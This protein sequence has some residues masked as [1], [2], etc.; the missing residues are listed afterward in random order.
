MDGEKK[1]SFLKLGIIE[2]GV[3]AIVIFVVVGILIY[4]NAIP[5]P[6]FISNLV[7]GKGGSVPEVTVR[8]DIPVKL[9]CPVA[10]SDCRNPRETTFQNQPAITYVLESGD[11]IFSI[12]NLLSYQ[13][14]NITVGNVSSKK[15]YASYIQDNTCYAV[16][17]IIPDSATVKEIGELPLPKGSILGTIGEDTLS[18]NG[19][20][21]SLLVQI[22][23]KALDPKLSNQEDFLKCTVVNTKPEDM[24]PYTR[25]DPT[26]FD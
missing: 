4:F 17:Y 21:F 24:G 19:T 18:L 15:L 26:N 5:V 3:V 20:S 7:S 14:S 2:I 6:S 22:Q 8:D 1:K 16:T 25:I 9:A 10:F 12:E 23:K 13:A 11:Q